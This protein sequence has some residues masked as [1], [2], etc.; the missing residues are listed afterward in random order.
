MSLSCLENDAMLQRN[1]FRLSDNVVL[2]VIA[3]FLRKTLQ[4]SIFSYHTD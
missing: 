3:G 2:H 4:Q 1:L